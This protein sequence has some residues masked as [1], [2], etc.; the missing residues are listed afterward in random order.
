MGLYGCNF[1]TIM[2]SITIL[3]LSRLWKVRLYTVIPE[4]AAGK[5]QPGGQIWTSTCFYRKCL[6]NPD[7]E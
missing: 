6:L 2:L 4:P 1:L 5:L 7:L 3:T